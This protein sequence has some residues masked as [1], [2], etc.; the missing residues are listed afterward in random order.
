[1]VPTLKSAEIIKEHGAKRR[2]A[3]REAR[4][5]RYQLLYYE[6]LF[7]WLVDFKDLTLEDALIQVKQK[8]SDHD[9]CCCGWFRCFRVALARRTI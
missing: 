7:A 1:M 3:E 2:Q 8:D 4:I 5:L 9:M 6:H